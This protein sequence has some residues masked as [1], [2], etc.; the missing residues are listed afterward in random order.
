M[1]VELLSEIEI[2]KRKT[3]K[4]EE[5]LGKLRLLIIDY[6]EG[7]CDGDEAMI[8]VKKYLEEVEK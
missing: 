3:K 2:L 4:Y 6:D 1:T 5:L 8:F 7:F